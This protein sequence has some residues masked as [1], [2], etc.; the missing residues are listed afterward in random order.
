MAPNLLD[1]LA[2]LDVP[3]PPAAFDAELHD[4]VNRAI[5]TTQIADLVVSALPYA[6]AEFFRALVGL[7]IFTVTGR[8]DS[9]SNDQRR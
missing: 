5:V 9:K 7:A 6:I 4:K 1:Q 2:E 8:Y 3:P